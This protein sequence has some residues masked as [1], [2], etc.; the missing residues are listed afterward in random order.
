MNGNNSYEIPLEN[1]IALPDTVPIINTGGLLADRAFRDRYHIRT[2]TAIT[3]G[4]YIDYVNRRQIDSII[5]GARTDMLT[6]FPVVLGLLE[7]RSLEE[8][9]IMQVQR[10]PYL[11][12]RGHGVLIGFVDTGIDYTQKSFQ[13]EDGTSK[14]KYIWDQSNSGN[15]PEGF[16]FG[17]EYSNELINQAL[18]SE[19]PWEV[20]PHR[21]MVG[22]GT[23]LASIAAGRES[24]EYIGA[25]PDAEIIAVKLKTAG[26]FFYERFLVP[27]WQ[28]NAYTSSDFM[29]GV[30]YIV[31]KAIQLNRPVAIC[32][33][34]GSN[35]GGLNGFAPVEEYLSRVSNVPGVTITCAA[36]NESQARH[37]AHGRLTQS[38]DEQQ[39]ELTVGDQAGDIYISLW[40]NASDRIAVSITSPTGE[41]VPTIPVRSGASYTTDLVFERASVSIEYYLTSRGSGD[42]YTRIKILNPTPGIWSIMVHGEII[43]DGTYHLWLP[44]TGFIDSNIAFLSPSANYTVVS[45]AT[46]IGVITCGAYDSR[47]NSLY[48][49]SSWGPTRLPMMSPD[50]VA[51]G[52]NVGGVYPAGYGQMSGTS[53][54]AAITTGA[55]ALMLQWGIVLENDKS[56]TSSSVKSILIRGSNRETLT[57]IPNVQWGYG[58]LDLYNAL[59]VIR[60]M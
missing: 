59:N 23:F 3:G 15:A 24:G 8:A 20:V 31:N 6:M 41:L 7:Q 43:L 27:E 32:V 53:V 52:V 18:S 56:L 48:A 58:K 37:H 35:T 30:Q 28:E 11:D 22:H 36:G 51:P 25:A 54:S 19:N 38:G 10:H 17:T 42:Q 39:V 14:I 45:P 55:C 13:Y 26:E 44:I 40:N 46:A 47:N 5:A 34:I 1:F 49:A 50:L 4:Y 2:G 33:A 29:L 21:D 12:L 9:G 16:Y 57:D 60:P